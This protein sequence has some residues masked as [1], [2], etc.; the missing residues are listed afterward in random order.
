MEL[1]LLVFYIIPRRF[2]LSGNEGEINIDINEPLLDVNEQFFEDGLDENDAVLG[3]GIRNSGDH[4]GM[5]SSTEDNLSYGPNT[6]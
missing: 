5:M 3:S 1:F 6:S 2:Y 4:G